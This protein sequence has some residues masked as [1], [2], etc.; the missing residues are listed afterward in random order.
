MSQGVTIIFPNQLFKNNPAIQQGRKVYLV[1]EWLYFR[2]YNFH[3][4][5]LVLHRASMKFYEDWLRQAAFDV[6]YIES[7]VQENDCRNLVATIASKQVT[8]IHIV[9]L[10]DNWLLK[11]MHS[12]CQ[13]YNITLH[14][15]DN[16]NF[17]NTLND[18][19]SYF[20]NKKTYFSYYNNR[21]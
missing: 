1:E 13:K 3:Q 10:I 12:A 21:F 8:D 2:Q 15:Y 17:L 7:Q 16:P 11:R 19:S 6:E 5:K 9:D 14:V 18:T 4:Q 20:N